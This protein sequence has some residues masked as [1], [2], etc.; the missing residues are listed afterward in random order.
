MVI[1]I[2]AHILVPEVLAD[3]G[4]EPWRPAILS[5]PSGGYLVKNNQ[6]TNGPVFK[7]I[8]QPD[9]IV[10]SLQAAGV[11]YAAL[12]T[13][14]YAFFYDLPPAEGLHACAIQNDGL[15]EAV[16]R[17]PAH[18]GG[19]G[20]LP[21]QDVRLAVREL[22]RLRGDLKLA[23]VEIASHINGNDLGNEVYLPFW[24]AIESL[25]AVVFVHPAY[26]DQAGSE[27]MSGYY[28]K[29]LLGNPME[30]TIFAAHIIFS[31]VLERFPRLKVV[32]AHAGGVLPYLRGR[33]EHGYTV[34]PE[35]RKKIPRP[36]GEDLKMFYYDTITHYAPTLQYL[37]D[38]VGADHVLLG[39]DYPFDMGYERPA[40]IVHSLE[41]LNDE[42]K[43]LILGGN[44]RRLLNL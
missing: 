43:D 16:A 36:P 32:L 6:F 21:M 4:P 37:V 29:N 44:A 31:G 2:H 34:R 13:P 24:E 23:G 19:L 5:Y 41:R 10:A 28:L 30:T 35:P 33:L 14:P 8:Y 40:E 12:S 17:R 9:E 38:L 25:D 3:R 15:A 20:T 26:F 18:I 1:D 39:S 22:E 27:R 42:Q 11:D 7:S